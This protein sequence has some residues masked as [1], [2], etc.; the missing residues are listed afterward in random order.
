MTVAGYVQIDDRMHNVQVVEGEKAKFVCKVLT[1]QLDERSV[2]VHWKHNGLLIYLISHETNFTAQGRIIMK[3]DRN[4]H[5]LIIRN[6]QLKDT[7]VYTCVVSLGVD[8]AM[9]SAYLLVKGK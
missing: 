5:T 2:K 4:R 9:S 6:A 7:G 8:T 3:T 1:H